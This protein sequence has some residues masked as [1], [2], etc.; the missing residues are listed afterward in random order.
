MVLKRA[1]REA[2]LKSRRTQLSE[3]KEAEGVADVVQAVGRTPTEEV[4]RSEAEANSNTGKMDVSERAH[5]SPAAQVPT[6]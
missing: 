4:E 2:R 6:T 1:L 3:E 5:V